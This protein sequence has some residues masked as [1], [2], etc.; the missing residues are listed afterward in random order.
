MGRK[1]FVDKNKA[2][3][4]HLVHRSQRDPEYYNEE[5][6]ERVLVPS[7]ALKK[8][9]RQLN[10]QDL[11]EEY[12]D[13]V[14]SNEGEA[15]AYGIFFDDTEYDYMQHLRG[16]GN[17]D[18]TWIAAPSA[19]KGNGQKKKDEVVIKEEEPSGLP[20]EV[21]PSK[22]EIEAS[23]QNQQSVPDAISGFQPDM[24]PRLREVLELLEHSDM[25]DEEDASTE[26]N[27]DDEFENLITSGKVDEDEFYEQQLEEEQEQGYNEQAALAAGKSE[28]EIEFDKFKLEQKK[29]PQAASSDG[30]FSEDDEEEERRDEVPDLVSTQKSKPRRKAKTAQSSGSMSSS[31]LFRNEG[32]SFLDDRFDKVEE[33]YVPMK[34]DNELYDPEQK[35]VNDLIHDNQFN[36]VLD[37]FLSSYGPNLGRKKAPSRMSKAKKKASLDE[38]DS[39]RRQLSRARI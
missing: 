23:Y 21:L 35:D 1:K 5:A 36:N 9:A 25:E 3:T 10:R 7:D 16:T 28:W 20:E 13:T 38:L 4:F 6:T 12:G 15:A 11:D 19:G 37:D 26:A 34:D 8:S 33:E 29:Q 30:T 27:L 18:A 22:T 32:L 2:Q 39:V 14:R 17:Q 31:A 24:D